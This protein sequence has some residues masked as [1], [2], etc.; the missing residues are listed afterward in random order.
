MLVEGS[1]R[2]RRRAE[3]VR[4]IK[5]AA[6]EQLAEGGPGG[7]SL[8]G[9][10]RAVGMTVQSL[11][12]YFDSRDELLTALVIDG[13][14]ALA[15]SVMDAAVA[16]R[17]RP[18]AERLFAASNAYRHWALANR[19]AFL[20]LYGTPVPGYEPPSREEVISASVS[21]AEPFLEVVFDGWSAE[22]LARVPLQPGT[23]RLAEVDTTKVPLPL[24]ALALFYELRAQMHGLV[25]L[26]LVGHLAPM[27]DH[28][29][30]LFRGMIRRTAAELAALKDAG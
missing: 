25:M 26:E 20:L 12:H 18:H 5:A 17:G 28:G 1:V 9:V 23:E 30:D 8:R 16:T 4:E 15:A 22:Q 3:T 11:Y 6:L 14:R 21:L 27:N 19:P 29:E 10:A 7:L 13:H 24:G 2:D